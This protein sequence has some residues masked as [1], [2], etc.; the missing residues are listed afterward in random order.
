[1]NTHIFI[2]AF[3]GIIALIGTYLVFKTDKKH[4]H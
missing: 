2:T 1:M 3:A 4:Q